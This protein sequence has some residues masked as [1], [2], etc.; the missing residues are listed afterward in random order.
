[1]KTYAETLKHYIDKQ[2]VSAAELAR[3]LGTSRSS[4]CELTSGRSKEPTLGKAKAIAD[5]LGV[6]LEEMAE[7]V[8]G[9]TE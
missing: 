7:M 1:M 2:G 4:I 5:A 3:R 9:D 6:T 8:Y